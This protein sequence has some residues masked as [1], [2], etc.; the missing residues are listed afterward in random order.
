MQPITF[1]QTKGTVV[2]ILLALS[3]V[4]VTV[5]MAWFAFASQ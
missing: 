1:N 5:G 4:V 2:A 3:F